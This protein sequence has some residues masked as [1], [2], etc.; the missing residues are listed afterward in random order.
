MGLIYFICIATTIYISVK[1]YKRPDKHVLLSKSVRVFATFI[2]I[3]VVTVVYIGSANFLVNT[4]G[5]RSRVDVSPLATLSERQ[6]Q[7]VEKTIAQMAE[8][9][10]LS[11]G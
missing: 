11:L 3:I 7:D 4:I 9:G 10:L 6:I 2:A 8:D 1:R 5:R